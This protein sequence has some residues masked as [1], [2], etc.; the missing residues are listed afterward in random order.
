MNVSELTG[1]LLDYWVAKAEGLMPYREDSG[2][3]RYWLVDTPEMSIMIIG[4]KPKTDRP[5]WRYSPSVNWSQGG[6]IIQRE[7]IPITWSMTLDENHRSA[8]HAVC[9]R[10]DNHD[11]SALVA[12]MRAYVASKFG[13]VVDDRQAHH[14]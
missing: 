5:E 14:V 11:A 8:K 12:A 10:W 9:G 4:Q 7:N 6:P 1:P 2:H 3:K 13:D